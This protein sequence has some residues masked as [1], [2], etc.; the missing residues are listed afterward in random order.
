MALPD[1]ERD[2]T[3]FW[4]VVRG[5]A[6][7]IGRFVRWHPWAF[8]LAVAG[9]GVFVSAIVASAVVVGR[10][11]DLVIIP[12]LGGGAPP[13]RRLWWAVAAIVAVSL[14]KAAGI[15]LRRTAA[16]WLQYRTRADA[17]QKLIDHQLT[18]DLAWHDSRSTGD[19]M[20]I[21]EVDTQQGTFVLAP[22][23]Y[24]TGASFLLVATIVLVAI[25][26]PLLG[27][28]ALVGLTVVVGVDVFGAFSM[29][30]DFE[31]SQS[32]RGEVGRVAHESFDGALTVKA[33]GRERTEEERFRR[34]ADRLRDKL[35]EVGV[36][37]ASFRAWVEA[38]PALVTLAILVLGAFRV[39]AGAVTPGQLVTVAYLVTLMAFPLQL[40]GFVIWEMAHSQ[41]A[42]TRV[43]EVLDAGEVV[44]HGPIVAADVEEGTALRS[45]AVTFAYPGG[46]PVLTDVRLRVEPGATVALVGP[47]GSGKST[48]AM[49]FARLWDP[50]DGTITL[51]G[52]DVRSFARS[53]LPREVA[54]V[55]QD[56]FLFDDT[57]RGNILLGIDA[58]EGEFLAAARLAGVDRF[59]PELPAGYGTRIGERG[60]ALSGGQRQRV[61]LARALVRRPRLLVLDDA[62]SAVDPS[63]EAQILRRL[64]GSEL[65][66]T[67]VLVAYRRSSILLA[68]EVVFIDEG[69]IAGH[70]SHTELLDI[71]GYRRLLE[72]YAEDAD[73]R[74]EVSDARA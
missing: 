63:V 71:P 70:G 45:D 34:A 51:D 49:L 74:G 9:A 20:S 40:L 24:A 6:R 38:L 53:E 48:L 54:Y 7:L 69:R 4:S 58:P 66:S 36:R 10:V 50:V 22:L 61:A 37:F 55:A 68:D 15:T 73:A 18:L 12:V 52:R 43:Q 21:S 57:V 28:V 3:S 25:I 11:S 14:W 8:T 27:L 32:L 42:W 13:D 41:A 64:K 67:I 59:I 72:A 39:A 1:P 17:R 33:L 56:A 60:T 35:I 62:T 65:P 30:D 46:P 19:L 26:D 31:A 47:T 23:P 2:V 16:S 44:E 29:F 5:G